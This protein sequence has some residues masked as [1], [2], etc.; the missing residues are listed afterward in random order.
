MRDYLDK[1]VLEML[2]LVFALVWMAGVALEEYGQYREAARTGAV[3]ERLCA[4]KQC[5]NLQCCVD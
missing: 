2:L 4:G 5:G 3:I 1:H